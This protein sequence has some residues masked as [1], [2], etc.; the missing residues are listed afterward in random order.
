MALTLADLNSI[1][2][3]VE[4]VVNPQFAEIDRQFIDVHHQLSQVRRD[5]ED[6]AANT[7]EQFLVIDKR[8]DR[9]DEDLAGVKAVASDHG[10]RITRLEH[11]TA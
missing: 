10:Y 9:V 3:V 2:G 6:L 7:A 1:K 11:K 5:I 4:T 8:F